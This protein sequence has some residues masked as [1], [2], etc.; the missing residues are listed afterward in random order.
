MGRT[1]SCGSTQSSRLRRDHERRAAA[2]K[3]PVTP[4]SK[5]ISIDKCSCCS[6]VTE[7]WRRFFPSQLEAIGSTTR[8]GIRGPAYTPRGQFRITGKIAGWRKS[9]LGLLYYPQLLQR[10][11]CDSRQSFGAAV[12]AKPRLHSHSDV[13]V[14]R[15]EQTPAGRNDRADLRQ[16]IVRLRELGGSRQAKTGSDRPLIRV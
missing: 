14:G 13:R 4:T 16:P 2:T 7:Q 9:P 6:T 1:K 10:W 5:S 15:D 3:I 12:A 11:T 8:K